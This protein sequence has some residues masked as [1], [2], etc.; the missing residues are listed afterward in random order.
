MKRYLVIQIV[1]LVLIANA[2]SQT[3]V[4]FKIINQYSNDIVY[5]STIQKLIISIPS[6]DNINGNSI[7]YID[8]ITGV[9]EYYF[10]GSEPNPLAITDNN[11]YLYI[12][13]DGM[14]KVK[15]FNI[16]N[17]YTESTISMGYTNQFGTHSAKNISCKPGTDN[18]IAVAM[19]A[20]GNPMGVAI[21]NNGIKLPDTLKYSPFPPSVVYFD[22]PS[23]L[24][25][26]NFENSGF[27]FYTMAVNSE[28]VS[29]INKIGHLFN[30]FGIDFCI[31]EGK[32]LSDN[33]TLIE[34]T[35]GS[36]LLLAVFNIPTDQERGNI[37]ACFDPYLNLICFAYRDNSYYSKLHI[38][39][40]NANTFL[41]FDEI[42]IDGI[43]EDVTK[44]INWG[45]QTKY[46]LCSKDGKLVIINGS[47]ATRINTLKNENLTVYPNPANDKITI[48]CPENSEIDILNFDGKYMKHIITD[49]C[50][51]IIDIS[52]FSGGI[53]SIIIKTNKELLI[54]KFIKL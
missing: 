37:K 41:K 8:P 14:K 34:L 33:G 23:F 29:L 35:S 2:H 54:K 18:I 36:P 20:G 49:Q 27:D 47:W 6:K 19:T 39:R 28:G 17:H 15:K 21:F 44:F 32:A 5:D 11:K 24:Y 3:Y 40:F 42:Q 53:Y 52:E 45:D 51:T 9:S 43:K 7:G 12:G 46:A 22:T 10:I 16:I 26:Y 48:E 13:L 38:Q 25:G 30:G 50:S 31:H 1:S 4:N